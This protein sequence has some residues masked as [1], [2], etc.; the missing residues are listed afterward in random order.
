ML[1]ADNVIIRVY[2]TEDLGMG[3]GD[4]LVVA[5]QLKST[6]GR[7]WTE[8]TVSEDGKPV[9]VMFGYQSVDNRIVGSP[10]LIG[11]TATI[12]IELGK[13][14]FKAYNS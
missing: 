14:A 12:L 13:R 6:L 8:P 9:D 2:I 4:K 10:E 3:V 5:N 7:I 1:G 11:T